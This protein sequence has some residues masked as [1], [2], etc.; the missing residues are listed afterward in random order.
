[1]FVIA[2]NSAGSAILYYTEEAKSSGGTGFDTAFYQIA[3]LG[4]Q[5]ITQIQLSDFAF[6]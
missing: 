2:G 3:D 4:V 6:F 5:P 1:M